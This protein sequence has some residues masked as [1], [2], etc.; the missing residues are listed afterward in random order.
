M[1]LLS[2]AGSMEALKVAAS[3]GA[4]AVYF[5][6]TSFSA[7]ASAKNFLEEETKEAI[8]YLKL[9]GVKSYITVNTLYKDTEIKEAALFAQKV[10]EMGADALIVQDLG[11]AYILRKLA[12]EIPLHGSTQMTINNLQG[13]QFLER[14]GFKRVVLA[15][16]TPLREIKNII[17]NSDIEIEVFTHGAL[18]ISYSGNCL[19][20]SF[21]GGRSG[22]RGR[23]AQACRLPY[24]HLNNQGEELGQGYLLSPK[25]LNLL[26]YVDELKGIGI[27]S[28]KIEGRMK[29]PEYVSLIT[30][31]YRKAIDFG[32]KSITKKDSNEV[33]QIFNRG[34]TK[35]LSMG[36]FGETLMSIERPDNRGTLLGEILR[37]GKK[38]TVKLFEDLEIGDGV[39]YEKKNGY[40]GFK[41]NVSGSKG[42]LIEITRPIDILKNSKLYKTSSISLLNKANEFIN[43]K[44][45]VNIKFYAKANEP[46]KL[47]IFLIDEKITAKVVGDIVEEA[48]NN[49]LTED[50][51]KE[52]LSKLGDTPYTLN[53]IDVKVEGNIFLPISKLNELRRNG[54]EKLNENILFTDRTINK[55]ILPKLKNR[56]KNLSKLH[57]SVKNESQ[58]KVLNPNKL[59]RLI[60]NFPEGLNQYNKFNTNNVEVFYEIPSIMYKEDFDF[61]EKEL[62]NKNFDGFVCQNP[63]AI[64]FVREKFSDKKIIGSPAL[65]AMNSYSLNFFKEYTDEI[66]PSIELTIKEIEGLETEENLELLAYGYPPLMIMDYC[67]VSIKNECKDNNNCDVCNVGNGYLLDK[68][69]Y[70]FPF[71]RENKRTIIYNGSPI[72][73]LDNIEKLRNLCDS[74][75][76]SFTIENKLIEEIQ[77]AYYDY[78]NNDIDYHDTQEV[79]TEIKRITGATNGH[80][81]RG[82]E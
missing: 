77:E 1:E 51:I 12:P 41:S 58:L 13:A 25:D 50:R 6:G 44:R 76:L 34:F 37:F 74:I 30:E 43:K 65:N 28:L 21:I 81:F 11:L 71:V 45:P 64:V 52:N 14:L 35:G 59:D 78:L 33:T 73:M 2:P 36:D 80:Y 17:N 47:E 55:L 49:P 10:Y 75:R 66:S 79:L 20:S 63:G 60:V 39:E 54:I 19:M 3:K 9:R 68:K 40:G 61:L 31:K 69:G 42:D 56:N 53:D 23:C 5:G 26:V 7:R 62:R 22:N 57:V 82:I 32:S 70:R 67:P 27:H 18:C 46:S 8:D 72:V 48:I 15:R 16:E 24:R 29:R 4:D 38:I